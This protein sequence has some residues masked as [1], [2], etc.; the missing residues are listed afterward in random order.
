MTKISVYSKLVGAILV[1][2]A[3]T[4]CSDTKVSSDKIGSAT[5]GVSSLNS[6]SV[7][8]EAGSLS[9]EVSASQSESEQVAPSQPSAPTIPPAIAAPIVPQVASPVALVPVALPSERPVEGD[10][11]PLSEEPNTV[12]DVPAI[13]DE[14]KVDDTAKPED[15]KCPRYL[16]T[17]YQENTVFLTLKSFQNC[18]DPGYELID[19]DRASFDDMEENLYFDI[20]N[21]RDPATGKSDRYAKYG[22]KNSEPFTGEVKISYCPI[23]GDEKLPLVKESAKSSVKLSKWDSYKKSNLDDYKNLSK[24]YAYWNAMYGQD[25]IHLKPLPQESAD[26]QLKDGCKELSFPLFG[27]WKDE[28]IKETIG[29]S[30]P[31]KGCLLSIELNAGEVRTVDILKVCAPDQYYTYKLNSDLSNRLFDQ[32]GIEH[33]LT[34]KYENGV[35]VGE[36]LQLETSNSEATVLQA[37]VWH[38]LG[39]SLSDGTNGCIESR[40]PIIVNGGSDKSDGK[41]AVSPAGERVKK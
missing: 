36:E 28:D 38:C 25:E 31:V 26:S 27:N 18:I 19:F 16:I 34:Q 7:G 37:S 11:A 33:S 24:L 30:G 15:A 8:S 39:E 21:L 41:K 10:P 35:R 20:A 14:S 40:L 17:N 9:P 5:Q 3:M 22:P 6:D 13:L 29:S 12:A 23:N 2:V 4:A 1:S 32:A